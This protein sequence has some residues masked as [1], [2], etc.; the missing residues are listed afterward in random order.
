MQYQVNNLKVLVKENI[1]L[2]QIIKNKYKLNDFTYRIISRSIDARNKEQIYY[3]Y[4][5]IITTNKKIKDKNVTIYNKIKEEITYPKW[6]N[7]FRPVIVGFGPAGMFAA[8]YLARCEAN[9]I[10]IERGKKIEDRKNDVLD[11]MKN[12][13]LNPNSNVQFGEGG[14]GA[15]SDGKLTTNLKNPLI[16]FILEEMVKHG[17]KEDVMYD[18][19]PHVGTDY[20]VKVVSSIREEI[21][22]LGGSFYFETKFIDAKNDGDCLCVYTDKS[23]CFKTEHLLIG[24]GHSAK[25]TIIHLHEKMNMNMEAKAF[26]M[27]V[28]IEHPKS[29]IDEAQYGKFARILPPAYYKL[30]HHVNNRG[31]YTFCM[32]PGGYVLASQS[33]EFSIVT[34][35]M[36]NQDRANFNSNSALLVDVLPSDYYV[37]SVLDGI[38]YQEKYERLAYEISNDYKAPAN[39]VKEF[40]NDCVASSLR[41]VNTTYPHGLAFTDFKRCLPSFVVDSLKEGIVEFDKKLKGFAYDDAVMIGIES[42]SSCPIRMLRDESRQSNIKGI[43]PIGEGAGY[44]GGITSAALDG[45][46]T[47]MFISKEKK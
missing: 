4:R 37:S 5:L 47:A 18:A 26:S 45:L 24:I 8:L 16:N 20:L 42:R 28:R 39:L 9:P 3:I 12:K 21:I 43:Y 31:V 15:F 19:M 22:S 46:I 40:L 30:A 2:E 34:N 1:N 44:A 33:D 14:A 11:F 25:D 13:V 10:I 32:C 35:G 41:S 23:E 36:S 6:N 29:L 17:A 7:K 38:Y 27:G